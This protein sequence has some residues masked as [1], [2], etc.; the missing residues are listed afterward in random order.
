MIDQFKIKLLEAI[1]K[2]SYE[3]WFAP[4][5]AVMD[6]SKEKYKARE[7]AR[8]YSPFYGVLVI[9]TH[10]RFFKDTIVKRF[11]SLIHAVAT[12]LG[13]KI[14]HVLMVGEQI[15]REEPPLRDEE[16]DNVQRQIH[17]MRVVRGLHKSVEAKKAEVTGYKTTPSYV[18]TGTDGLNFKQSNTQEVALD[19][20][21][22]SPFHEG[23]MIPVFIKRKV[24]V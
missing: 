2:D 9:E 5:P 11:G 1:S 3:A 14:A 20:Q 13:Y 4:K 23:A 6:G 12:S 8:F 7:G 10:S 17:T 19:D 15:P 24:T 21:I 18:Y 22:P 16:W